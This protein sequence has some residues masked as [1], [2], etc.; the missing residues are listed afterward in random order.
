[1]KR[2]AWIG[3]DLVLGVLMCGLV[4]ASMFMGGNAG[5][6]QQ[7]NKL[8]SE[9][10]G[11]ETTAEKTAAGDTKSELTLTEPSS[12]ETTVEKTPAGEETKIDTMPTES[13]ETETFVPETTKEEIV[14]TELATTEVTQ[15]GEEKDDQYAG[16]RM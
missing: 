5:K 7:E 3:V 13:G 8:T 14:E 1:M 12:A 4:V 15:N 6:N 16:G 11:E 9:P 2:K 10:I